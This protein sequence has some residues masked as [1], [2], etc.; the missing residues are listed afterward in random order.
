MSVDRKELSAIGPIG[1]RNATTREQWIANKLL[2][3]PAGLRLLDA[4]AGE[5]PYKKYCT[6]LHYVSQDFAQYDGIGNQCGLQVGA[7]NA[8]D[9]SI[10]CD[11]TAIPEPDASFDVILC[12]EVLEHTS[13]PMKV[14]L[15]FSRLLKPGGILLI[16]A[17]F[18]SLTHFAP[19]HYFTGFN[20]YFYEDALPRAG[21]VV[22]ELSHNGNFFESLAQEMRRVPEVAKQY[23]SSVPAITLRFYL[24]ILPLFLWVLNCCATRD[25]GSQDL[26]CHGYHVQASRN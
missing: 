3:L 13:S 12:T 2:A 4:G 23:C 8:A 20:R 1:E 14:I 5:R 7:W 10:I 18:S 17:P 15:E 21:F 6:H 26:A 19:Y 22:E 16:T 11:I 9:C 25:A 24:W